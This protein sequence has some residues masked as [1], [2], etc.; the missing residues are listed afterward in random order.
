MNPAYFSQS[1]SEARDRFVAAV[2][3]TGSLH[4]AY[5]H[6]TRVGPAG[7][8]LVV[9][10]AYAGSPEAQRL[11]VVI[12][13]T[14]GVEGFAGSAAQL[15]LMQEGAIRHLPQHTA[16]L[17]V[18]ALNP[19]GF[20][21]LRRVDECNVDLNRNFVEHDKYRNLESTYSEY[22][23]FLVPSEWVG[24]AR[25]EAD[26]GL[27][28]LV[29]S[30][31]SR[32]VQA[33]ITYGQWTNSDGLFYGGSRPVWSNT[34]WRDIIRQYLVRREAVALIDIHTGLGPCGRGEVIFRARFDGDG[35]SR[36]RRWYGDGVTTSED[37]SSSSTQI[38]GNVHTPVDEEATNAVLTAVTLEFGTLPPFD[39]LNALRADNWL[40]V[41]GQLNHELVGPIRASLRD[42]FYGDN[43]EW[44]EL[45]L[46]DALKRLQ[47]GLRGI[48]AHP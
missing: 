44:K 19:Y 48:Q 38:R 40:Y 16:V 3:E 12:S 10:V 23:A 29:A 33:A 37:G 17:L 5:T 35:Y 34:V 9:D 2:R 15:A 27:A 43:D 21:Y 8:T 14:H 4:A 1:Y 13:G 25:D 32:A 22:H 18:H 24:P 47:Q 45:V 6:P 20:A 41:R 26:A 30:R 11:L 42:A 46:T 7:E 28:R 39:V 36:A 31:G